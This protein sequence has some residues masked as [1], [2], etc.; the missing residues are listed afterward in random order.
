MA[1]GMCPFE[2][3]KCGNLT[4]NGTLTLA[5]VGQNQVLNISLGLGETCTFKIQAKCGLPAFE[6]LSNVTGFDIQVIDYDDDDIETVAA[7]IKTQ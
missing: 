4:A 2:R 7:P 5:S 1:L 6:P 3:K